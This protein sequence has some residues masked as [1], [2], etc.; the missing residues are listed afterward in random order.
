M[1][2]DDIAALNALDDVLCCGLAAV[3]GAAFGPPALVQRLADWGLLVENGVVATMICD[4]CDAPHHARTDQQ[5][6]VCGWFCPDEG[7][8]PCALDDLRRWRVQRQAFA[9]SLAAPLTHPRSFDASDEASGFLRLGRMAV[10]DLRVAILLSFAPMSAPVLEA[11][12]ATLAK[13]HAVAHVIVLQAGSEPTGG[14][15]LIPSCSALPLGEVL[16]I[17]PDGRVAIDRTVLEM[18]IKDLLASRKVAAPGRPSGIE[19]T[20]RVLKH[21]KDQD[22]QHKGRNGAAR[23]VLEHWDDVFPGAT[24]PSLD[25]VK[26]HVSAIHAR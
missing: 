18:C 23:A 16:M 22:V 10:G 14:I 21:L 20:R 13:L 3:R 17:D 2:A 25:T 6:G 8:V 19:A 7:F 12:F 26:R 15:A 11:I 1:T 5:N 24:K 4:E 9:R